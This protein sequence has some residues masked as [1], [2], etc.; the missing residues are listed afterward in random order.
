MNKVL[1][2][3]SILQKGSQINT[4][5]ITERESAKRNHTSKEKGVVKWVKL[6]VRFRVERVRGTPGLSKN[7]ARD[8]IYMGA[9]PIKSFE[10]G[11]NE[12]GQ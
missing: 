5:K 10:F 4:L 2:F 11:H 6:A 7:H 3:M 8:N 12:S 1:Q 9:R